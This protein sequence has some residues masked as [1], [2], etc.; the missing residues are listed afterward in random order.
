MEINRSNVLNNG[1]I[2]PV[3]TLE[4]LDRCV[5]IEEPNAPAYHLSYPGAAALNAAA[6][7]VHLSVMAQSF[8]TYPEW[9]DAIS[10]STAQDVTIINHAYSKAKADNFQRLVDE[11]K[12][13]IGEPLDPAK[14]DKDEE[15]KSAF[16]EYLSRSPEGSSLLKKSG[17]KYNV[18][19]NS[20]E[21]SFTRADTAKKV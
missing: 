12:I 5:G 4:Y 14:V 8:R 3:I 17:I 10:F 19:M 2:P 6:Y 16:Y 20:W 7:Q 11:G 13:T 1:H 18:A 21:D 9:N 15:L